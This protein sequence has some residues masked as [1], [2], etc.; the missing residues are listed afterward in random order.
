MVNIEEFINN[1]IME[2]AVIYCGKTFE[3]YLYFKRRDRTQPLSNLMAKELSQQIYGNLNNFQEI[4]DYLNN[5]KGF[6][7]T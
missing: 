2:N 6:Q 3:G 5:S 4:K 1:I 7:I